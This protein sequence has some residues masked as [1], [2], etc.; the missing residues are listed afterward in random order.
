MFK[1]S[2]KFKFR[3]KKKDVNNIEGNTHL[4]GYNLR[5]NDS[6]KLFIFSSNLYISIFSKRINSKSFL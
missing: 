6:L 1:F 4:D 3:R 5:L 2:N